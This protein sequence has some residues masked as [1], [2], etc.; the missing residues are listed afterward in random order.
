MCHR[1][2]GLASARD[3]DTPAYQGCLSIVLRQSRSKPDDSADIAPEHPEDSWRSPR[4]RH[5]GQ[6]SAQRAGA[7]PAGCTDA[8]AGRRSPTSRMCSSSSTIRRPALSK[9]RSVVYYRGSRLARRSRTR[10]SELHRPAARLRLRRWARMY[11]KG[12]WAADA[13][14]AAGLPAAFHSAELYR[15]ASK[16]PGA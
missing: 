2:P 8:A 11:M 1:F 9:P 5:D 15:V 6:A 12:P 13:P 14:A 3:T 10:S 16:R 7:G 4:Q